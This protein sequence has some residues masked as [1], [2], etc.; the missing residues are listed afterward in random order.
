MGR[1][2]P[3]HA[4]IAYLP[5]E[6]FESYLKGQ[7]SIDLGRVQSSG[8][9]CGWAIGTVRQ[10]QQEP[11]LGVSIPP[12]AQA[13]E[14]TPGMA[15]HKQC[16]L[17]TS[18]PRLGPA[19]LPLL[20]LSLLSER[21]STH[22]DIFIDLLLYTRHLGKKEIQS[23]HGSYLPRALVYPENFYSFLKTLL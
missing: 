14:F 19:C 9:G 12:G 23:R 6:D 10:K 13:G 1:Q 2:P 21:L 7:P 20:T 3:Q 8:P 16:D 18:D 17:S 11:A 22:P 5:N 15:F 4:H